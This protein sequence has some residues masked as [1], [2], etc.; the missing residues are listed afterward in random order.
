MTIRVLHISDSHVKAGVPALPP[1]SLADGVAALCGETTWET[2][3][4]VMRHGE[5]AHGAFDVVL[6]TGDVVDVAEALMLEIDGNPY[7]RLV[8]S[9]HLHGA[10]DVERSDT[11]YLLGPSTCIQLVH[12]HP[13]QQH[14]SEVTPIG[15]R[16]LE[17]DPDGSFRTGL[18]GSDV[19]RASDST[20]VELIDRSI[21]Q[22]VY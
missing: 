14:N 3:R 6:H 16:W 5:V 21:C 8:V 15:A 10:G 20:R 11:T 22:R 2:L 1:E 12:Q 9:G 17:L 7:V 19:E 18:G 13:L 4:S